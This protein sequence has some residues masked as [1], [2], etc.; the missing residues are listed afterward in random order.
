MTQQNKVI[1]NAYQ[2]VSLSK[3][4]L[5]GASIALVAISFFVFGGEANPLWGKFWKIR[6]LIITPL[7]GAAG[8][9][10][11]YFMDQ[12]RSKGLLNPVIAVILSLVIYIVGLWMGIVLGLDGTMWD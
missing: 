4:T 11:Y 8:G 12:L 1:S 10:F 2:P 5:I 3:S 7:A 6:P 9:A